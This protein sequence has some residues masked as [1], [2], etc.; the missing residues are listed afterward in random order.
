MTF[1]ILIDGE[2]NDHIRLQRDMAIRYG[3]LDDAKYFED[4]LKRFKPFYP[5][6]QDGDN[7]DET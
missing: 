1:R 5:N 2:Y 3:M 6:I 4:K 7:T